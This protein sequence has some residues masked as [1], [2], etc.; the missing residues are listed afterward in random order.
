MAAGIASS[1]AFCDHNN[2]LAWQRRDSTP[3]LEHSVITTANMAAQAQAF[4]FPPACNFFH[5]SILFN[6]SELRKQRRDAPASSRSILWITQ[7]LAAAQG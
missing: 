3:F 7:Q 5:Q 4:F 2:E 1:R 6:N